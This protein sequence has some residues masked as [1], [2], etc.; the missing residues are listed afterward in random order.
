MIVPPDSF[1]NLPIENFYD[2]E[3]YYQ[4]IPFKFSELLKNEI[5]GSEG[6]GDGK[7]HTIGEKSSYAKTIL[8]V[9]LG[10]VAVIGVI[11]AIRRYKYRSR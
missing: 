2:I 5:P 1:K 8:L 3:V 11:Y 10:V 6:N 9:L 7:T 4:P